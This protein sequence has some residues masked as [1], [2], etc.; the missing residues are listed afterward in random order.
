MVDSK[1]QVSLN[2][3]HS[4]RETELLVAIFGHHWKIYRSSTTTWRRRKSKED[5]RGR[6]DLIL[7]LTNP[8]EISKYG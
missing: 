4:R 6:L 5:D 7:A 3:A 8:E 2:N 1:A